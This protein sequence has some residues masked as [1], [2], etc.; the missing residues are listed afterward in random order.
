MLKAALLIYTEHEMLDPSETHPEDMIPRLFTLTVEL[1][2]L[3][4]KFAVIE[5]KPIYQYVAP[6]NRTSTRT[7]WRLTLS[8]EGQRSSFHR[9]G[10]LA[11][12]KY[13]R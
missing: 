12:C 1:Q 7:G 11:V 9:P 8:V 13:L 6:V 5:D 2:T 10:L 3:I 4:Y